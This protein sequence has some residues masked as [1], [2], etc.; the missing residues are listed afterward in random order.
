MATL[1]ELQSEQER[2]TQLTA[3]Q[4]EQASRA[5][6]ETG[7]ID[8]G[9]A[10]VEGLGQGATLGFLDEAFATGGAALISAA[11]ALDLTPKEFQKK[12]FTE[13]RDIGL[14]VERKRLKELQ[15]E[16]PVAFGIG[17]VAGAIAVPI[18]T[19]AR[20]VKGLAG[21]G[22][23]TGAAFGAGTSE[24]GAIDETTQFITDILIGAGI[25]GLTGAGTGAILGKFANKLDGKPLKE[26]TPKLSKA[27]KVVVRE[28][29]NQGM[30]DQQIVELVKQ[31][32]KGEVPRTVAELADS[33]ALIGRQKRLT[34]AAGEAGDVIG[35]FEKTR[36]ATITKTVN[37]FINDDIGKITAPTRAGAGAAR[38]SKEVVKGLE[39]RASNYARPLYEAAYETVIDEK[40]A[41]SIFRSPIIQQSFQKINKDPINQEALSAFDPRSLGVF[42]LVKRD[43]DDAISVAQRAGEKNRARQIIIAKDNL[44][45]QLD[46]ISPAYSLARQAFSKKAR[47]AGRVKDS[48]VGAIADLNEGNFAKAGN[49]F[50][51]E[52]AN[53]I[54][55]ASKILR[56]QNPK[57][58]DDLNAAKL[59][60]LM[61]KSTSL[62]SFLTKASKNEFTLNKFRA[63][64]TPKQFEGFKKLT[65]QIRQ[66]TRVKFGS[67]TATNQQID[68]L[69]AE[70]LGTPLAEISPRFQ[71][72]QTIENKAGE[73]LVGLNNRFQNKNFAELARL[74]TGENAEQLAT[75]LTTKNQVKRF[76]NIIEF[77]NQ[78]AT[79]A[80]VRGLTVGI[81]SEPE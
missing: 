3:L 15:K 44:V 10:F 8:T 18:G 21:V 27:E 23:G 29:R 61:E 1:A 58:V 72:R 5:K 17:E 43:L 64:M 31:A 80:Q 7:A 48:V 68:R 34:Q 65:D 35:E 54:R 32:G 66:A 81:M 9:V 62:T 42:D 25:G 28:L 12:S 71:L 47:S 77:L 26:V 36:T 2:R 45:K 49:K 6:P 39:K 60:E 52:P 79:P 51:L 59:T 20:G 53:E 13:L 11:N 14:K 69:L 70:E 63:S 78:Q 55:R 56:L 75:K 22:A 24:A 67:D 30:N 33:P 16:S 73:L 50:F 41:R 19:G 46:E 37:K 76:E 40:T 38:A 57:V 74:F 4:A